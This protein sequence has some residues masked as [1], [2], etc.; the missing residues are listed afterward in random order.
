MGNSSLLPFQAYILPVSLVW[1]RT[2]LAQSILVK[3]FSHLASGGEQWRF[4]APHL[5][6]F[7]VF[8]LI[9]FYCLKEWVKLVDRECV[10]YL[11]SSSPFSPPLSWE[12]LQWAPF[13]LSVSQGSLA[14]WKD[15]RETRRRP[16]VS[17]L[18]PPSPCLLELKLVIA[19]SLTEGPS[20]VAA[21]LPDTVP[22]FV[23]KPKDG[24]NVLL[25]PTPG[26]SPSVMDFQTFPIPV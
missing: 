7:F 14:I 15:W 25:L 19:V 20:P 3:L 26:D 13:L 23:S 5:A 6:S 11:C 12:Y 24:N 10:G 1:E 8:F 21:A 18:T 22:S 16:E 17:V 2:E 4:L 9:P